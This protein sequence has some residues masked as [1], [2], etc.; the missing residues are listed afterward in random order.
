MFFLQILSFLL[1][2]FN[3]FNL[4]LFWSTSFFRYFLT[5][6]TPDPQTIQKKISDRRTVV[7]PSNKDHCSNSIR[8]SVLE[9]AQP[10]ICICSCCKMWSEILIFRKSILD[11]WKTGAD[12]HSLFLMIPLALM[13]H[14]SKHNDDQARNQ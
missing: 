9:Q 13:D 7:I 2:L 8:L 14:N 4:L 12:P 6:E 1:K 3:L 10:S 11:S 5:V